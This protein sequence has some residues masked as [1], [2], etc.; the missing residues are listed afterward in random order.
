MYCTPLSQHSILLAVSGWLSDE[1]GL[2]KTGI[3]SVWP[4]QTAPTEASISKRVSFFKVQFWGYLNVSSVK[5][6]M[7]LVNLGAA[8][9]IFALRKPD[10]EK[11]VVPV[12]S[13]A[14][15]IIICYYM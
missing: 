6:R 7:N 9:N 15:N 5:S 2:L 10:Y 11:N 14:V 3:L 1:R 8:F 13:D 12:C 4:K